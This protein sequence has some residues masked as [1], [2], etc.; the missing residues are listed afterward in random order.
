MR[1]S[2]GTETWGAQRG[3]LQVGAAKP[4][5]TPPCGYRI[6]I[7]NINQRW[8][9]ITKTVAVKPQMRKDSLASFGMSPSDHTLSSNNRSIY[10]LPCWTFLQ[11]KAFQTLKPRNSVH[12]QW[13]AGEGE[14]DRYHTVGILL[15]R[16]K[17]KLDL[18][19]SFPLHGTSWGIIPRKK[20]TDYI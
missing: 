16:T 20:R 13:G 12:R 4:F 6:P 9:T 3:E 10:K 5:P 15:Q 17:M 14:M 18:L 7:P 8:K 11:A 1:I 19:F 2:L